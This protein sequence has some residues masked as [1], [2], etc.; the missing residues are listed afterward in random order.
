[1]DNQPPPTEEEEPSEEELV[2]R[3]FAATEEL[4]GISNL[5]NLI[6]QWRIPREPKYS[7]ALRKVQAAFAEFHRGNIPQN[8]WTLTFTLEQGSSDSSGTRNYELRIGDQGVAAECYG[9]EWAR[10]EGSDSWTSAGFWFSPKGRR[11]EGFFDEFINEFESAIRQ[12]ESYKMSV[13]FN[14]DELEDLDAEQADRRKEKREKEA[15]KLKNGIVRRVIR[16]LQSM[17]GEDLLLSG[18]DTGLRN[19]WDEICVEQQYQE[20]VAS[21]V[22]RCTIACLIDGEWD[23]CSPNDLRKLWSLTDEGFDWWLENEEGAQEPY[24]T[25]DIREMILTEVLNKASN[26]TNSRIQAF[27][28]R[29]YE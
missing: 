2:K 6:Q 9:S 5:L 25:D 1:M 11:A 16:S 15:Q 19:V 3:W 4:G 14:G 21:D 27:I 22:Y 26:Y 10:G 12:S 20:S 17:E 28:D 18:Q 7:D 29:R 13:A 8:N 24:S 23:E